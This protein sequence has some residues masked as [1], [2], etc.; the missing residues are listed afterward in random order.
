M[1]S[2]WLTTLIALQDGHSRPW[3]GLTTTHDAFFRDIKQR[4]CCFIIKRDETGVTR[5]STKVHMH[6]E[7]IHP[8]EGMG[9]PGGWRFLKD[10][11]WQ[12]LPPNLNAEPMTA[13]TSL[14]HTIPH[15]KVIAHDAVG[16]H[17]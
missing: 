15:L 8:K 10:G 4:T 9:P 2:L 17:S 1:N 13:M 12:K 6:S 5:M 16:W 11:D 7:D 14:Q 3:D